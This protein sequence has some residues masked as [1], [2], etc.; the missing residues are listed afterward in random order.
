MPNSNPEVARVM[1]IKAALVVT[2]NT[3]GWAY[4]KTIADNIVQKTIDEALEEEDSAKRDGKTLK[5]AALRKGFAELF[6]AVN[7]TMQF[8]EQSDETDGL[9]ELETAVEIN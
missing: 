8:A 9:G 7:S 6:S 4:I 3:Q 5:A 1:A 2:T